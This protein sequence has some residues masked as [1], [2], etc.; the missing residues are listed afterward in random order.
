MFVQVVPDQRPPGLQQKRK[1]GG[2]DTPPWVDRSSRPSTSLY[3]TPTPLRDEERS[4]DEE[5]PP[6][7]Y[8]VEKGCE[9]P[10]EQPEQDDNQLDDLCKVIGWVRELCSLD[11]LPSQAC[12]IQS[13]EVTKHYAQD[14]QSVSSYF[15][16]TGKMEDILK[17][18]NE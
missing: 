7:P 4:A 2:A 1:G 14:H 8:S 3:R 11:P 16:S 13:L 10:R 5:R 12:K 9:S 18:L 17:K 15:L 6:S